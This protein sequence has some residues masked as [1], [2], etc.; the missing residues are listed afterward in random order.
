MA[1]KKSLHLPE[2]LDDLVAKA[3]P[4]LLKELVSR[5]VNALMSAEADAMCGASWGEV[6]P[7]RVNR[8]NG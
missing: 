1:V 5:F 4:D 3:S 6:S 8:R 7:E 2:V